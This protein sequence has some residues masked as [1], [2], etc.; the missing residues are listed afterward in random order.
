MGQE[1]LGLIS[2]EIKSLMLPAATEQLLP[3][4]NWGHTDELFSPAYWAVQAWL[5]SGVKQ[6]AAYRLGN[7]LKEEVA[8]CLLGGY[9]IPAEV[10]LAAYEAIRKEGLLS[11]SSPSESAI[12]KVLSSPLT[13]GGRLVRYR[14]SAQKAKFLSSALNLLAYETPENLM[15]KS[16][17]NWLKN[18]L[19]GVG[20]KTASWITRN[21][22]D[23][24][25][26]AILDIH[27]LRAGRYVGLYGPGDSVEKSYEHMEDKFLDFARA[28]RVR[29][30]VLDTLMWRQMKETGHLLQSASRLVTSQTQPCQLPLFAPPLSTF[31]PSI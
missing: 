18:R 16:F 2:G 29:P 5:D 30:A 23:S 26:V 1:T 7:T 20:W 17:R 13:V 10:G 11:V 4:V 25:E 21:F 22:L 31:A 28:L 19:P 8:A 9:G 14:F 6:Y 12:F 15:D 24:D 27:I 3:G